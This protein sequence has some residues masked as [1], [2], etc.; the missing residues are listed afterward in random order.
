MSDTTWYY[1]RSGFANDERIGPISSR[2]VLQLVADGQIGLDTMVSNG[3]EWHQAQ[4]LPKLKAA[5]EKHLQKVAAEKEEKRQ[6]KA[7]A[8]RQK[9]EEAKVQSDVRRVERQHQQA[10]RAVERQANDERKQI[11]ARETMLRD[12]R[13][14]ICGNIGRPRTLTK[15]SSFVELALYL[16]FCFPGVIYTLWRLTSKVKVCPHCQGENML[17][18][19]SPIA[20]KLLQ[21]QQR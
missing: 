4:Q 13:N 16:I 11:Q 19:G 6:Q 12:S 7:A 15:G 8:K 14:R 3:T 2:D 21:E 9:R 17:P 5:I 18:L 20:Q 10:D 1:M